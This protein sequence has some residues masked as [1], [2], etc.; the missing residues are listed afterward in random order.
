MKNMAKRF[1]G[2]LSAV[3][4]L[5]CLSLPAHADVGTANPHIY[6]L[7]QIFTGRFSESGVLSDA[8]WGQNGKKPSSGEPDNGS[9]S[10]TILAELEAVSNKSDTEK[11]AVIQKYVDLSGTPYRG[12]DQQPTKDPGSV[13][14]L[15][16][17]IAPGY[18]LI[19]DK[20]ATQSG[21]GSVYTLYLARASGETLKFEP[22]ES[23]PAV[24]KK[25][26]DNGLTSS[27]SASIGEEIHYVIT[28]SVPSR[29]ADYATYFYKFNDT[30]SKG[31]TYQPGSLKVHLKNGDSQE[32]VT[33]YFYVHASDYHATDGTTI[34]VSIGDLKAL[35]NASGDSGKPYVINGTSQIIVTYTATLNQHALIKKP[36]TNDVTLTYS[37]NPNNSGTPSSQPP[38]PPSTPPVPSVPVGETVKS[39]TET[40]TTSLTIIKTNQDSQRLQGAVF[41]LTGEGVKQVL[42]T[43]QVF[44]VDE[45]GTYY[46]LKDGTYTTTAPQEATQINYDSPT[47]KY[48]KETVVTLKGAGQT[49][50]NV[51]GE[52]DE[53]GVLVF[54]GLGEGSYTLTETKAPD[55]YNTIDPI[56]IT[57][58]FDRE[59]NTFSATPDSI[60]YDPAERTLSS[61]IVNLPGSLL[62]RT[63]GIGTTIFY[64][65]GSAFALGAVVFWAVNQRMKREKE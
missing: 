2:I 42:V 64:V 46:K 35:A 33:R 62:P 34:T 58:T 57:I 21:T 41:T 27:N 9:V 45:Q 43:E 53:N 10:T 56:Q 55:G 16:S 30:L 44:Q 61:T 51:Q 54:T 52:V 25:I 65:L 37:N 47:T 26:N 5:S 32:D 7:Y 28:G 39:T 3:I 8:K 38:T 63:G 40:Y 29:I 22:K 11:L 13:A 17:G 6:E 48:R 31:L 36:N 14:Y 1:C 18:Y 12:E 23:I 20:E 24:N 59:G 19:K 49:Q 50:T 4:M 60:T 15:Y